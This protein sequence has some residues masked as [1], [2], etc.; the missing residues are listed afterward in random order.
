VNESCDHFLG[1]S[2]FGFS[3]VPPEKHP[4]RQGR[5]F[6]I[7]TFREQKQARKC[8]ILGLVLINHNNQEGAMDI[9]VEHQPDKAKLEEMGV[10]DWPVWKKEASTF[11][12][13]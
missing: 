3:A 9:K 5:K 8:L 2:N 4:I 1:L 12:W 6:I 13:V 10:F 11:P 7:L